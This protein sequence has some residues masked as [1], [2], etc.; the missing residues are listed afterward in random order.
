M[1]T[2]TSPRIPAW[3][4]ISV[5]LLVQRASAQ[6]ASADARLASSTP[7]AQAYLG[8][9]VSVAGDVLAAGAPGELSQGS[10]YV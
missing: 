4:T 3:I 5:A 10:V 1:P 9:S 2:R 7:L 6:Y 8:R